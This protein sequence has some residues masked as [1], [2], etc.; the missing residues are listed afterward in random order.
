[1]SAHERTG[2]RDPWPGR[3]I[4]DRHRVWGSDCPMADIDFL[5]VEYDRAT[6]VCLIDWKDHHADP[7]RF[8]CATDTAISRLASGWQQ[9]LPYMIVRYWPEDSTFEVHPRNDA[10]K[11]IYGGTVSMSE[12]E[13][14]ASLYRIREREIPASIRLTLAPRIDDDEIVWDEA[15]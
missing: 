10:A 14:A 12:E 5:G 2:W 11:R 1:V 8:S 9:P 4:S 3:W 15:A 7:A 13:F 6:P